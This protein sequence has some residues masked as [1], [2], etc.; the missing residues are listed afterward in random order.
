MSEQLI[1]LVEAYASGTT[2]YYTDILR[3][4]LGLLTPINMNY[5]YN[6]DGKLTVQDALMAMRTGKQFFFAT[7]A[8]YADPATGRYY[9]PR[10]VHPG[11][12]RQ[13]MFSP[14]TTSGSSTG[15]YGEIVLVNPDGALDTLIDEGFDG[16]MCVI[17][18]GYASQPLSSFSTV[19]NGTIEQCT[20]S[21]GKITLRIK[22]RSL[23]L[24]KPLSTR[25][26]AGNNALPNGIEG[27]AELTGK[28]KPK[29]Y[30]Q[31]RNIT[32]VPVNNIKWVYQ[33]NDGPIAEITG[34][35]DGGNIN[36]ITLGA[37]YATSAQLLAATVPPNVYDTCY[38]EGLFRLGSPPVKQITCDVTGGSG[39]SFV[40]EVITQIITETLG[41]QYITTQSLN[42]LL[43]SAPYVIG[44]YTGTS[45]VQ[46]GTAL[47][48]ICES[49]G[50]WYGFDNSG[51]F[52]CKQLKIPEAS[53]SLTTLTT[54]EILTVERLSTADN[55][56]GIP[57]WK[58]SVDYNKNWTVQTSDLAGTLTVNQKNILAQEYFRVSAE[59]TTVKDV[60][61]LAPEKSVQTLLISAED[62]TAE[63]QRLLP[64]YGVRRDRLKITLPSQALRY[65]W[66]GFWDNETITEV[67]FYLY[68]LSSA[69]HNNYLYL[70]GGWDLTTESA[71][72]TRLNLYYP[73]QGWDSAGV[74]DLP[75]TRFG[76]I[77]AV[78]NNYLYVIG[79]YIN[80]VRIASVIRLDLNNPTGAW[81]DAGVTDLPAPR[82]GIRTAIVHNNYLYVI[83]GIVGS[84]ESAQVI[85]LNLNSPTGAWDDAGVTN[86]PTTRKDVVAAVHN[87]HLYVVGGISNST[88]LTSVIRLDL[89]NPT[90]AW[91]DAGVT[92]LP[93]GQAYHAVLVAGDFLYVLGGILSTGSAADCRRLDLNNPT[94]AWDGHGVTNIPETRQ[95]PLACYVTDRL[96]LFGGYTTTPQVNSYGLRTNTNPADLAILREI[97]RA[98]TI[99]LPRY[100]YETGRA[101]VIIGIQADFSNDQITL[102]LWG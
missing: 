29:M 49:V 85:R 79:G 66:G 57:V 69:V 91:D 2:Q 20:V 34:V 27:G 59:D 21:W 51:L 60:H 28:R 97:G 61:L 94:G 96:F 1:Y 65:P 80:G 33:I 11:L 22:D 8:G 17:K 50:A 23:E 90:G 89:N 24:K 68:Q 73:T 38:A 72:V 71:Q 5:D 87:N 56:K 47:D 75:T 86:L 37:D 102:E 39:V 46:I 14:G 19:F 70:T 7:G 100:G 83:G 93:I 54:A 18:Q 3:M 30:G 44:Y 48:I 6:G 12:F 42:E 101:M 31:C 95:Y 32:P 45:D 64:L 99:K 67:P 41:S 16:R 76:H 15:G 53:Q 82:G 13:D 25:T 81:D 77:S 55:D 88:Y 26:Y 35:H 36:Q 84:S 62:A 98:L 4:A 40:S 92:D 74:T 58:T 78:H 43:F 63:A 52:W 10:I 9:E